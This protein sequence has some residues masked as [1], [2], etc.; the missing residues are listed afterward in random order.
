MYFFHVYIACNIDFRFFNL[1][2]QVSTIA[3]GITKENNFNMG[4]LCCLAAALANTAFPTSTLKRLARLRQCC[5]VSRY[6][7]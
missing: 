6:F 5:V 1:D 3:L 7:R 2:Y 4:Y